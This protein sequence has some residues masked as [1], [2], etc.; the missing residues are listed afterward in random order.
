LIDTVS[1]C[2][3]CNSDLAGFQTLKVASHKHDEV[4]QKIFEVEKEL[5]SKS[6]KNR[7][8]VIFCTVIMLGSLLYIFWNSTRNSNQ[9]NILSE[10]IK[11]KQDSLLAINKRLVSIQEKNNHVTNTNTFKY[12]VHEG[13]Y[14]SKIAKNFYGD[15][16][17]YK[18]LAEDNKLKDPSHLAIGDTI[19]INLNK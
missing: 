1:V 13:D 10:E 14:L 9:M 7:Q 15:K 2:P 12:V 3:Q 18:K 19:L 8:M 16:L 4:K 17:K 6:R 11:Q 5:L